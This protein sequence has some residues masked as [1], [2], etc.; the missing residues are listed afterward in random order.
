MHRLNK[1]KSVYIF[2]QNHPFRK[3]SLYITTNQYPLDRLVLNLCCE[4]KVQLPIGKLIVLWI[5]RSGL[6]PWP[7]TN[8]QKRSQKESSGKFNFNS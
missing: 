2:G 1:A 4:M 8:A 3:F 6:E 7:G 5:E